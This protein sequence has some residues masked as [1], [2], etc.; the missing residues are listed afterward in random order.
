MKIKRK[1]CVVI[2]SIVLS[3][4]AYSNESSGYL[5]RIFINQDGQL[6]FKLSNA[7]NHRPKCATNKDWDYKIDL[8]KPHSNSMMEVLLLAEKQS[9]PLKVGYGA[10]P[11]CGTGFPAI[12]VHYLYLTKLHNAKKVM[13]AGNY[14]ESKK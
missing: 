7:V 10:E 3:T 1:L 6:L 13:G 9:K 4:N 11:N 12:K 5:E 2:A 8:R 14:V